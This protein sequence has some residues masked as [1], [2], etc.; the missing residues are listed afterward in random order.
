MSFKILQF[1]AEGMRGINATSQERSSAW[2]NDSIRTERNR[3]DQ[4]SAIYRVVLTGKLPYLKG[5][6]FREEDA[7][8]NLFSHNRTSKASLLISD[9][10]RKITITRSRKMGKSTTGKSSLEVSEEG[11]KRFEDDAAQSFLAKV[12]EASSGDFPRS[13]YLHQEA[14]HDLVSENPEKRSEVIDRLLGTS[15]I[16]D[17][18]EI[19]DP[20]MSISKKVKELTTTRN[21]IERDKA[22]FAIGLR[23]R[24]DERKNELLKASY[25]PT[26]LSQEYLAQELNRFSGDLSR[27]STQMGVREPIIEQADIDNLSISESFNSAERATTDVD[28]QR[29]AALQTLEAQRIRV[30]NSMDAVKRAQEQLDNLKSSTKDVNELR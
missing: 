24:L 17:L 1:N 16:R 10:K 21:N 15:A 11:G 7:I 26:Q 2:I 18:I 4:L 5:P 19:V 9:G 27:L 6:D 3:Q 23:R 12:L 30:Q 22:Q 28:R 14:I 29:I 8:V 25:P 20:K 13:V